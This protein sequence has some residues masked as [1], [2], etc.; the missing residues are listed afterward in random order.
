MGVICHRSLKSI[1]GQLSTSATSNHA[2]CIVWDS[3]LC[4]MIGSGEKP[5]LVDCP[6][7]DQKS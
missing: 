2:S 3:G 5:K 1:H 7:I 6:D 4:P